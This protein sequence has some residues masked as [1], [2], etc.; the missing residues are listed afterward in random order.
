MLGRSAVPSLKRTL[1]IAHVLAVSFLW[2]GNL[3]AI[4]GTA[5]ARLMR[6][7]EADSSGDPA[8]AKGETG[9][10]PEHDPGAELPRVVGGAGIDAG[11]T[12]PTVDVA[13]GSGQGVHLQPEDRSPPHG[14]RAVHKDAHPGR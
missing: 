8:L 10:V 13:E 2:D 14:K 12:P 7:G 5:N 11:E 9:R 4:C 1:L 3:D 6:G